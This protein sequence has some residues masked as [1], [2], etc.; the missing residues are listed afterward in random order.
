M[1]Q[2]ARPF[3]MG[4]RIKSPQPLEHR[5]EGRRARSAWAPAPLPEPHCTCGK[6]RHTWSLPWAEAA[7]PLPTMP[8]VLWTRAEAVREGRHAAFQKASSLG[9]ERSRQAQDNYDSDKGGW[10][11]LRQEVTLQ[12]L[13]F[14]APF[15]LEHSDAKAQT[16]LPSACFRKHWNFPVLSL[17]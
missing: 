8:R 5:L 9:V 2:D 6:S 1:G 16:R 15:P 13:L 12:L 14:I 17:S 7:A 11:H 3:R 10:S 4:S